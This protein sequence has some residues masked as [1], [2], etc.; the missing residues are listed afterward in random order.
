MAYLVKSPGSCGE[1]IQGYMDGYSFMVTCPVNRYSYAMSAMKSCGSSG[2]LPPKSETAR[3]RTLFR[4]GRDPAEVPVR[5]SSFIPAGKGMASSTADISA[6]CQAAA[7]ACGHVLAPREIAETALSIEPS[8]A[9]FFRGIVEFDYRK[10][11]VISEWGRCPEMMILVFDC[12][13][14]IDTMQFNRRTDLTELQKRNEPV[15]REAAALFREGLHTGSVSLIGRAATMSAFANQ[16]ILCK[17]QL[18]RLYQSGRQAGS[19]GVIAAHS[20]TVLGL[21]FPPGT[22][23]EKTVSA[24]LADFQE[25]L[26]YL[27][28]VSLVNEGLTYKECDDNEFPSGPSR[29]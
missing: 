11:T 16:S 10:G 21:I 1:F 9:T 19:M 24:V 18:P 2:A 15:V 3:I 23:P 4:W 14:Q 8:D 20:G 26:E 29:R 13:G 5:L 22:E 27:D 12:G 28:C 25:G 6:V 7:L 17:E